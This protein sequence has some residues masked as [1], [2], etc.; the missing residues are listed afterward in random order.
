MAVLLTVI[1]VVPGGAGSWPMPP[2]GP[3]P[4]GGGVETTTTNGDPLSPELCDEEEQ[5]ELALLSQTKANQALLP[6]S[7]DVVV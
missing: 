5:R 1:P 6:V 3:P 7:D 2:P 4:V